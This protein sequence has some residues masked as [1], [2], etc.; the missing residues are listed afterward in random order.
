MTNLPVL[1]EL[2]D[3]C[4]L[5]FHLAAAVGV[6]LIVESPVNTI[7]TNIYGTEVVLQLANKKK[8]KVMIASTSEV[9]G[10]SVSVP[11]REDHDMV[12]SDYTVNLNTGGLFLTA[13]KNLPVG[14]PL[15]LEFSLPETGINVSCQ[16]RVAW[17]NDP[18][19]PLK[20]DLPS[21]MGLQFVDITSSEVAIIE[22][23]VNENGLTP[24]W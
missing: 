9:Y 1:A 15:F 14:T 2:V 8:K 16:A 22:A 17:I 18:E 20:S 23:Y 11:F 13:S 19:N 3:R 6:K 21:G 4:E 12:L 10:K 5:I 7:E 24:D